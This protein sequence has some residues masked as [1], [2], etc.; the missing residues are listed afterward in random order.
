VLG[1]QTCH[2]GA[3]DFKFETKEQAHT[4]MVRDPSA[5]PDNCLSC[6][7]SAIGDLAAV[8]AEGYKNSLHLNLWGEK[9]LI[10]KRGNCTFEGSGYEEDFEA[11]CAGCHTTCG[12]C[13]VSRP[14]SVGGGFP[15]LGGLIMLSHTFSKTPNM[16]EQCTACHGSRVGVDYL[17]QDEAVGNSPDVHSSDKKCEGCHSAT[18]I[19]GDSQYDGDHYNHR[20]E[21]K[22]MPRCEDCHGSEA[23]WDNDYH[24]AHVDGNFSNLQCQVCHSQP[25]KNCTNC[26]N[27]VPDEKSEKFDIDPSVVQFKIAKNPRTDTRGEYDYVVVRHVPVDPGTYADWGLILEDPDY[28]SEPTWKYTSPHNILERTPQTT[29]EEGQSCSFSCHQTEDSPNGFFLRESDLYGPDGVALPDY[30]A[31]IDIVIPPEFPG[32]K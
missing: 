11:K 9:A 6:H 7:S 18:E 23:N 2:G 17:G 26:H 19:H 1:C 31:N 15:K 24:N 20:Y 25:Y 21:V 5:D 29:V 10:E 13:H 4:D 16:T 27:L 22:T 3:A 32:G 30:E 12:Q 14:N 28:S 8:D